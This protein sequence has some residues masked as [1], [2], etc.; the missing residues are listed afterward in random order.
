LEAAANLWSLVHN[1]VD[2]SKNKRQ[3]D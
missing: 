1:S 3:Q 2:R